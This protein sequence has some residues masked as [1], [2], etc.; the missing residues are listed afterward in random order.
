MVKV[1]EKYDVEG[2]A[3]SPTISQ[4]V[5]DSGDTYYTL[6]QLTSLKV[7]DSGEYINTTY[8]T[9]GQW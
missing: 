7:S 8:I 1:G 5:S 4:E 2:Q 9:R 6:G 3:L